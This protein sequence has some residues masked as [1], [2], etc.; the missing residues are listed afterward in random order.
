MEA[1]KEI[2]VEKPIAI[3]GVKLIPIVRILANLW[4]DKNGV[5]FFASKEPIAVAFVSP[6]AKKA[7]RITGEEIT[8]DEL[9]EE[10]PEIKQLLEVK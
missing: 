10:V 6:S 3:T 2:T 7:F 4:R 5:S 8:L 1:K 9:A